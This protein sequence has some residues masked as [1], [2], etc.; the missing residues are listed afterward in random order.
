MLEATARS[1]ISS[2]KEKALYRK[3]RLFSQQGLCFCS[4]DYLSLGEEPFIKKSYQKGFERYASGSGGSALVCYQAIHQSLE[5]RFA[6]AFETEAALLFPSGYQANLGLITFF[7]KL[8]A[9]FLIDKALHASFYDGLNMADAFYKRFFHNDL[10]HFKAQ[11][12]Q[13]SEKDNGV[14]ITESVF[15]MSGQLAPLTAMSKLCQSAKSIFLVDEAHAFGVYGKE[16]LGLVAHQQ[17]NQE[18]VALRVIPFGKALAG[19]GAMIVGKKIWIEGI[20]QSARSLFYSTAPSPALCYGLLESFDFLR[21]ADDRRKKIFDLIACFQGL[22]KRSHL[23]WRSSASP[24]QQLQLGSCEKALYFAQQLEKN[25][26][27]CA[28][29]RPP[30]VS[31]EETGL[32]VILNYHHEPDD[33]ENLFKHLDLIEEA[34]CSGV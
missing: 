29:M 11:L 24:I 18:E 13:L 34:F 5:Q 12:E 19:Q 22:V 3:R 21:A 6:E 8:E 28:P 4:N 32:R 20:L 15:S 31:K 30:T 16:G 10:N 17:L 25:N 7:S 26:I 14:A 9:H 33:L 1:Y 23:K 27:F 2:L